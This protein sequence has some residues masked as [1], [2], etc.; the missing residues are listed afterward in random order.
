MADSS[1]SCLHSHWWSGQNQ[2]LLSTAT[3]EMWEPPATHITCL[4][5]ERKPCACDCT[6]AFAPNTR[7]V[8]YKPLEELSPVHFADRETNAQGTGSCPSS[9]SLEAKE[10]KPGR[11]GVF[12]SVHTLAP[13][14]TEAPLSSFPP[15]QEVILHHDRKFMYFSSMVSCLLD[16]ALLRSRSQTTSAT[17]SLVSLRCLLPSSSLLQG[18][19]TQGPTR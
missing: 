17:A 2:E 19:L 5:L 11:R 1:Q 13:L 18:S 15:N 14:P 16:Y 4:G 10:T 8:V 3:V 12:D 7:A 9:H 6:E